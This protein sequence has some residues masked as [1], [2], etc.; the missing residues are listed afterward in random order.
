[1]AAKRSRGGDSPA[2]PPK[3]PEAPAS[4]PSS[5]VA[6][7]PVTDG[8]VTVVADGVRTVVGVGLVAPATRLPAWPRS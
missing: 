7:E 1:M 5:P 6:Q 3:G 8:T 2:P 4:G